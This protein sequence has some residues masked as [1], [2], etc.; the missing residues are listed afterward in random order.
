MEKEKLALNGGTPIREKTIYYGRQWIEEDDIRAVAVSLQDDLITTG[1]KANAFEEKFASQ[2]GSDEAVVVCNGT[3]ALHSAVYAAGIGQGDEVIVPA[4][5][6]AASANCVVF[7]GGTPIFADV[8]PDTLLIDPDDVANKITGRTRAIIP[9]DY[10]GQACDY[11]RL[12]KIAE[13]SGL[14]VIADACHALGGTYKGR[15][16]GTLADMSVFSFHPVKHITSGEGGM[17]TTN[18]SEWARKMRIFR[19]HGITTD[20]KLREEKGTWFYEMV[21][22]GY[23]Y[24]ITDFQCALGMSQLRK[25]PDRIHRR[26]EIASRYDDALR[27]ITGVRPLAVHEDVLHAYHLYIVQLELD[28][29]TAD[30]AEIYRALWAEGIGVHV[31]YIPVHLHPYYKHEFGTRMGLCPIAE[32]AYEKILTLPLYPMMT[33]EDVRDVIHGVQKV[34]LA[35]QR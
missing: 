30:R 12:N 31:H 18:N 27:G 2:I 7:Q 3:A 24:R 20:H 26:R 9:V 22:L 11:D 10:S 1:P 17:I 15:M 4:M 21:D 16:V 35:Y 34:V 32:K 14:L 6:F 23:N 25:L 19:T 13:R 5:T 29:L 28:Q 8:D 33:D